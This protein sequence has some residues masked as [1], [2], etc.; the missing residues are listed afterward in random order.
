[1]HI[2]CISNRH[3]VTVD[4]WEQ[5]ERILAAGVYALILREK[6]LTAQE[7][8][9]YG[10]RLL[11]LGKKY[12]TICILHNFSKAAT[13]LGAPNFHCSLP[14][15]EAHPD[16]SKHFKIL[17][18]SLHTPLEATRATALG[19]TYLLAGHVFPT[20]CKPDSPP[21]GVKTLAEICRVTSLPV[22]A[23]GG[24]TP[25]TINKLKGL[26]LAGV[27]VMSGFM[28]SKDPGAYKK[29]L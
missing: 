29:N 18:V 24:I 5:L 17:G 13:S 11:Q 16:L 26:P 8:A 20:A 7:Y 27:A 22:Y 23:L 4:Y 1:M 12:K 28:T 9:V 14:Y 15:L 6:D 2:I 19:A 25:Q 21:L 10:A 3:L